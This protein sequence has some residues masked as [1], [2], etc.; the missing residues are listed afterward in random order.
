MRHFGIYPTCTYFYEEPNNTI[1]RRSTGNH[2]NGDPEY[3]YSQIGAFG[4]DTSNIRST[5]DF[6]AITPVLYIQYDKNYKNYKNYK[7][8]ENLS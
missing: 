2:A 4:V 3:H 5:I 7:N 6:R 8:N 1:F